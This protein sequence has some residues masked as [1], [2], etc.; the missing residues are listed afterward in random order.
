MSSNV[1]DI[2]GWPPPFAN[3]AYQPDASSRRARYGGLQVH[4]LRQATTANSLVPSIIQGLRA[5]DREL[6]SLLL[7]DDQG[8]SLFNAILDSPEYYLANKE[9]ALLHNEVHNIVASISSGDRLVELGAGNM[10]KT[11]L[12]LHTLQ[13]QRKYIH[14]IACDVD[15]VAL[16]RGLRNLQAIFPASTSS[17]KIQGLVATYEDCAAWLQRKS[18]SGHT[19]LMW[20]GNSL[21]NFPPPEASE[22][23]RSFLSTGASLILALDGCQDHEQIARAYEGP[24]NQKF[25][26]NGLRH[27]NDVLGTDAFDVRNWSF[28]GR[29][30][31]ELWMHESFYAAKRDLT[32]KIGRE[33]FVFRKGETIR[34]IRSGKWPKPK[35]VD[36]CR[37]AGGDVVDWWMNPDESYGKSTTPMGY[38]ARVLIDSVSD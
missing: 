7:W 28:L 6:P 8:L 23:I 20:L 18:G 24:S 30:N 21:A 17:I 15:R 35:V 37:E 9:W 1:Q 25:V 29:W 16:Q 38:L 4:N 14:Y 34:S 27:A 22:Y 32:L 2:C 11:A 36:I 5:E 12:I 3:A 33:T 26:L 19:S 13:S 10:K 31:P